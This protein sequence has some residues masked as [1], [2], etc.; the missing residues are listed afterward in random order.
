MF[1]NNKEVAKREQS[2]KETK[3]ENLSNMDERFG[4]VPSLQ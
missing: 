2:K 4:D 1:F 3:R